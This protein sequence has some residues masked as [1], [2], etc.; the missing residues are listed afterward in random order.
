MHAL[1]IVERDGVCEPEP[2]FPRARIL[3]EIYLLVFDRPPE[4]FIKHVV[5]CP[6]PPMHADAHPGRLQQRRIL[7]TREVTALI[8]RP[9]R[10]L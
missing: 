1:V 2:G 8:T 4:S 6:P 3:V 7:W 10:N 9:Y 5:Q